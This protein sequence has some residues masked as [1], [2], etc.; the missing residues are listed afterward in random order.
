MLFFQLGTTFGLLTANPFPLMGVPSAATIIGGF[1]FG[2]GMVLAGGC[3]VGTLYKMGSGSILSLMAFIGL[4][5][6]STIYAEF[7]HLWALFART[8]AFSVDII[9]LPQL[10]NIPQFALTVPIIM[11]GA[12]YLYSVKNKLYKSTQIDGYIQPWKT[13]IILSLTGFGSYL[14][15]GMPLGITTSYAKIGASIEAIFFNEHVYSLPYFNG[16]PLEYTPPFTESIISGGAG[17]QLDAIAAIQY[18]LVIFIT[19]GA[20]LSALL[21]KEF[22]IHYR[23]PMAQYMA[24]FA[25]GFIVGMAA[26]MV[27]GCNIWH[28]WGGLP[29]LSMQSIVYAIALVPG[30]WVGSHFL[31]K[32]VITR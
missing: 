9:T 32:Y 7:H 6:G 10:F 16:T 25:G 26:R 27:P 4:L 3:V 2:F 5:S 21:L 8:T 30:T 28:L 17:P 22:R 29:I 31:R 1:L 18:P 24:A 12:I 19:L 14:F 23:L 11:A 15:V 13:A 20:T